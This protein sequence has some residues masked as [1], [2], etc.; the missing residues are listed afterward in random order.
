MN[1]FAV[2][3]PDATP[4]IGFVSGLVRGTYQINM[5]EDTEEMLSLYRAMDRMKDRYGFDAVMRCAGATFKPNNKA[6]ILKR[7]S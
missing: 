1:L 3:A 6:E 2:P 4:L 5:F 7:K